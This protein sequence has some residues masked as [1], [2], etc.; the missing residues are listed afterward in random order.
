MQL[1]GV[2]FD[3][4]EWPDPNFNSVAR[5]CQ[6]QLGFLV[7][8]SNCDNIAWDGT[9]YTITRACVHACDLSY[10]RNSYSVL[11]K[12]CTVV[13]N[14]KSKIEFVRGLKGDYRF[15]YFIPIFTPVMHF[16]WEWPSKTA[17]KPINQFWR[18]IAQPIILV[19]HHQGLLRSLNLTASPSPITG[20]SNSN[21]RGYKCS[22]NMQLYLGHA[23]WKT[24]IK[25][26]N[27]VLYRMVP[28][29]TRSR[30][31][32]WVY[33]KLSYCWETVRRESMPMIAEVDVE[34]TT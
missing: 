9:D 10:G 22:T 1:N 14:P 12:L 18:L 25:S 30:F 8:I 23:W 28:L 4:L 5:V 34:M 2:I 6:R 16:Q 15:P 27:Y 13:W 3:D 32:Y 24:N 17:T 20:A 19:F 11:M 26:Y 21:T 33:K 31:S 7:F 29:S